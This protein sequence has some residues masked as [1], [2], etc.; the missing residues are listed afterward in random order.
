MR[1]LILILALSC[2]KASAAFQQVGP[3]PAVIKGFLS[4]IIRPDWEI[5]T[6]TAKFVAFSKEESKVA[7]RAKRK[8]YLAMAVAELAEKLKQVN[9]DELKVT[10]YNEV[11]DSLQIMRISPDTRQRSYVVT[12]PTGKFVRYFLV[13]DKQ[14]EAFV[15]YHNRVYLLLN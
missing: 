3:G 5:D 13:K 9:L 8:V 10:P 14:I 7:S 11:P 4:Y 1:T 6:V 15:L 12:D 2:F